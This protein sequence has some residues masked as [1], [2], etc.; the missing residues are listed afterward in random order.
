MAC[1]LVDSELIVIL[2]WLSVPWS[3]GDATLGT[4]FLNQELRNV[5]TSSSRA[6]LFSLVPIVQWEERGD[7]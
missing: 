4:E 3:K 1:I 5:T 2:G 7:G 6:I